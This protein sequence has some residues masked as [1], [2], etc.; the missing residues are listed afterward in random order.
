MAYTVFVSHSLAWGDEL[1]MAQMCSQLRQ[2]H[3]VECQIA[4]RTW[5]FGLSVITP[6]ENAISSAECVLALVMNDGT[7]TSYVNQ[8]LGIACARRKPVIALVENSAHLSPLIEKVP[9]L[10]VI[11]FESPGEC[12]TGLLTNLAALPA[13]RRIIVALYWAVIATLG[14][15][16]VSRDAYGGMTRRYA[17]L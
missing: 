11:E 9:D 2:H 15:I 10:R 4:M 3:G 6:L 17:A 8:E 7:A 13:E 14:M 5:K 12:A 16:F 1:L